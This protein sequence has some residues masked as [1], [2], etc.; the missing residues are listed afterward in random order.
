MAPSTIDY[1]SRE[2]YSANKVAAEQVLLDSGFPVTVLRASKVPGIWAAR[3]RE[4]MFVKR[5]L[6]RRPAVFLARRGAGADH[7]T[8]VVNA[9][10]LVE[11]VAAQPGRRPHCRE[12]CAGGAS[13][14]LHPADRAGY[15]CRARS[16]V[17]AGG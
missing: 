11:T 17:P 7:P 10:T 6:D 13:L 4:W 3:P 9:A 5:A 1:R 8:A 2:G 15:Q 14:G 16:G 12:W